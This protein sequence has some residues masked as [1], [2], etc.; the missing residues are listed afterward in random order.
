MV[1]RKR[2][3]S[4]SRFSSRRAGRGIVVIT[5]AINYLKTVIP[6]K[7]GIQNGYRMPVEDPAFIGDQA[8]HDGASVLSCRVNG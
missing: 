6:A 4:I 7:A 5:R 1:L 8:R 3:D 2:R